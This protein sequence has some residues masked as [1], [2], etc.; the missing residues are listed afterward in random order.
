[1]FL[2]DT[3][4]VSELRRTRPHGAV[5]QWFEQ[6]RDADICI[7]CATVGEIQAG[8]ELARDHDAAKAEEI[9][10]WLDQVVRS[11]SVLPADA[12]TFR[13]FAR[14]MHKNQSHLW[15]DALI[16]ATAI[17]HGATVVTRN[18]RDFRQFAVD[19]F[20]PFAAT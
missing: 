7:S 17:Q 6:T 13:I 5:L 3:N 1:M 11:M 15:D 20:D 16:A 14:L 12:T 2:L 8:I 18:T 4:V 10:R 9:E 19:L